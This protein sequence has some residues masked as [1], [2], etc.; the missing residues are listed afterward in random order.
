MRIGP[1]TAEGV[2][3]SVRSCDRASGAY[4]LE[5]RNHARRPIL[6][7]NPYP[8][9]DAHRTPDP[10][11]FPTAP[12]GAALMAHDTMLGPG[13]SLT[14]T[15]RCTATGACSVPGTYAAIHAYGFTTA[16][17]CGTYSPVWSAT[18]LNGTR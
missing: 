18:P 10:M 3:L 8:T 12:E 15:G 1:P 16:W 14:L 2:T 11:T 9:F 17:T 4:V 6:Y 7:L 5:L 13:E